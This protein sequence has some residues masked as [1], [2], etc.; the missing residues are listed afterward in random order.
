MSKQFYVYDALYAYC[1]RK[2]AQKSGGSWLGLNNDN[3][4]SFRR[5]LHQKYKILSSVSPLLID[6][7]RISNVF[8]ALALTLGLIFAAIGSSSFGAVFAQTNE[9]TSVA[10]SNNTSM[11][12]I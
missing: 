8:I 6:M 4:E 5:G 12:G 1:E 11:N 2:I 7:R 10:T 3:N 9:T